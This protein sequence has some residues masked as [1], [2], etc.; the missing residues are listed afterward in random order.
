[1]GLLIIVITVA[2]FLW[3]TMFLHQVPVIY[4]LAECLGTSS[5]ILGIMLYVSGRGVAGILL[6]LAH[7]VQIVISC[8]FYSIPIYGSVYFWV[9]AAVLI[10]F[11]IAFFWPPVG[12]KL[13]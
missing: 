8:L 1:M 3:R 2:L 9:F 7:V 10:V 13:K 5:A 11:V 12:T 6:V 4:Y